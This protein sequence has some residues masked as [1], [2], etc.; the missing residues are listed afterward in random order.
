MS[1]HKNRRL[2]TF[3]IQFANL[4]RLSSPQAK[5]FKVL[6]KNRTLGYKLSHDASV[7]FYKTL[8]QIHQLFH[9][10]HTCN[11]AVEDFFIELL[12]HLTW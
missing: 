4:D 9:T 6:K 7:H 8:T 10:Q 2:I 5:M 3:S 12:K 1:P 11:D